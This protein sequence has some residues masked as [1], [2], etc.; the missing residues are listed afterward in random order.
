MVNSLIYGK[1]PLSRIVC[2]EPKDDT[3]T[4]FRELEDGSIV[5]ETV[6]N[7]HYI[8]F[9]EQHSPKFKRL[10]GNQPYKW[11]Y[12]AP[13]RSKYQEI[14]SASYKKR[15]D[16]HVVRD[17]KEALMIKDG[18]TYFKGMKVEDVSV[19]SFDIETTGLTHDKN[20]AVL[21]IS[22][23]FRKQGKIERKLFSLDECKNQ[24]DMLRAW[25]NWVR[26]VNPSII[27]GH[28]ILSYDLPYLAHVAR[29]NGVELELGRNDSP[30]KFAEKTSQF[31]K[32]GSQSYDY[33]NA[34]IY[35]REIVD[36]YFLA[37]KYDIARNYENYGLKQIIKQEGL[38]RKGRAF[39]DAGQIKNDWH[40][41]E[42]RKQ[43]KAYA[44]DDADDSLKI[45]DLMIPSY[46][47]LT[48]AVP[49]SFQQIINSATGSQ[50]NSFLVRG[51]LQYGHS[52]AMASK[53]ADHT[54]GGISF[55]VPGVYKNLYKLD[56]KSAYPSQ[57]LRFKL[58]DKKKDPQALYLK[59]VE[60][61]AEERFELKR[62]YK[63]TQD[64]YYKDR[65]SSAK[66]FL[67]S[68]YGVTI[69]SG[70][71]YNAPE[72]GAK[73]TEETRNVIDFALKHV[74]G[75]DKNYWME[76]FKAAVGKEEDDEDSE[77]VAS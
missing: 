65:D 73:I 42:K 31:R 1:N 15:W 21:L 7:S 28:N 41:L 74:S 13:T 37:M 39:V 36:S 16:M 59:M 55:A 48:Q 34:H 72:L 56:L 49:R 32:D 75:K 30:I 64:K 67:N 24:G 51:Y 10:A 27:L 23:T 45:Y 17:P 61:F 22:N 70:L 12:E 44:I 60:F 53:L 20:S 66:V 40:D 57:I 35:G 63:E 18:Y 33:R 47:Y 19:L 25:T 46:F 50:I 52:I 5:N 26:L 29:L 11:L 71:N 14:L 6:P 43:I 2:I 76:K 69:T 54:E 8:L 62:L 68:A 9:T 77:E 3:A 4:I 58:Y 38:E